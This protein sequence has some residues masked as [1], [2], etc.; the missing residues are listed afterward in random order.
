M[1][2]VTVS[3]VLSRRRDTLGVLLL[4]GA[5]VGGCQPAA[6]QSLPAVTP[7]DSPPA[8]TPQM[9][10][11][12]SS[13]SA[14]PTSTGAQATPGPTP[15][16]GPVWT[17]IAS[18]PAEGAV[19]VTGVAAW[20][21]G[22]VAVGYEP[23]PGDGRRRGIVWQSADGLS[24]T[25]G[26]DAVFADVT[27]LD[28]V[29][30]RD[31]LYVFGQRSACQLLE[32]CVEL[33]DAGVAG[34]TSHD[35]QQWQPLSLPPSLVGGEFDGAVG[36]DGALVVH[37]S[38]GEELLPTVWSSADGQA[39]AETRDLAGLETISAMT[40]G[41]GRLVAFATQYL[42]EQDR[43]V[44]MAA[45]AEGGAFAP[46]IL[47]AGIDWRMESVAHG[48]AGFVAV[49]VDED[50]DAGQLSAA[51]L[52]S[53]DGGSWLAPAE[54]RPANVGFHVVLP[55]A[56][57]YV[58]VGFV[59]VES[60]LGRETGLSWWSADGNGWQELGSLGDASYRQLS[61]AAAGDAG[62]VVFALDFEEADDEDLPVDLPGTIYA[63]HAPLAALP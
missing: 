62:I 21:N 51:T 46:T 26:S 2:R 17:P 1:G 43:E 8:V 12:P 56:S 44:T 47:P 35:G 3:R 49:G 24:W 15:G 4:V 60:D 33:P 59:P 48:P 23:A 7:A 11:P 13:P 34:W 10:T 31:G 41:D 53:A 39:W 40:I 38:S 25:R 61:D 19:E 27:L 37:G 55:V 6:Q 32:E 30:A 16:G 29:A 50:I 45:Y 22:F 57:G 52:T 28:V 9:A 20:A 63:W 5:L 42:V 36:A 58:A 14:T 54:G 18:F